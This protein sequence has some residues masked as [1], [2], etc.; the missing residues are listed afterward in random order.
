[1]QDRKI[2]RVV[3]VLSILLGG[4]IHPASAQDPV[5]TPDLPQIDLNHDQVIDA[6]DLII[7]MSQ[8]Q[9]QILPTPTPT[10]PNPGGAWREGII[11]TIATGV[12]ISQISGDDGHYRMGAPQSFSDHGNGTITDNNTGLMW[13]KDPASTVVSATY[14]WDE[15]NQACASL[16]FSGYSDW[17]LP[18]I[19]ELSTLTDAGRPDPAINPIFSSRTEAAY[20]S[21]TPFKNNPEGHAWMKYS[22]GPVNWTFKSVSNFIRPVRGG[23]SSKNQRFTVNGNGTVS[24]NNTG[25]MWIQDPSVPGVAGAMNWSEALST[26]ESLTFAGFADW[27]LP[28]LN[29]V[30][31]LIDYSRSAPAIDPVFLNTSSWAWTSTPVAGVP[32]QSWYVSFD[33]GIVFYAKRGLTGYIRP[34]RS[35]LTKT[36]H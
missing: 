16:E 31:S 9:V 17:R 25:L 32:G 34:V 23:N 19:E 10:P 30:S 12:T 24:D 2:D 33:V 22:Y 35:A 27:R 8:W 5:P 3:L 1:M 20:W 11:G 7:F 4:L 6:K 21:A 28:N 18:S 26:C 29:E 14:T 13:L 15:A 36:T